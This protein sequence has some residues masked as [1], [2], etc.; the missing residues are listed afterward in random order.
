MKT[1]T[2]LSALMVISLTGYSQSFKT[3]QAVNS[4]DSIAMGAGYANDVYYSFED[5]VVATPPRTNWDIGFHT[6]VWTAS[7]ITNGAAGVNL[8][9]YPNSDTTGWN[10]VDTTG[11]GTWPVLYDSEND[12]EEGA[13]NRNQSGHP[14]YGWGKYNPITHDVVGDSIYILKALDGS[15]R[16]LWI[17]R[18]NSGANKY[19]VRHANLDGTDDQVDE[20]DINPYQNVNFIYFN[21]STGSFIEREP[22]T[23]SWDIQFTKYM[24]IQ[25]DGT[26]YPV[27]G[28][29]DNFK[30][31][32][33]EFYPVGPD[34]VDWMS[35]P[36]DSTK[37]PVGW[38]WKTF[39]M[40]TFT[41]TVADSTAFFVQ[42][43]KNNI[44]KLVFTKFEGSTTGKIV[45]EKSPMSSAGLVERNI[46]DEVTVFPN[47]VKDHFGKKINGNVRVVIYDIT[48]KQVYSSQQVISD[49]F[50]SVNMPESSLSNGLHLL[51]AETAEGIFSSKF[52]VYKN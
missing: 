29:L 19:F 39:D 24:A 37:S 3:G 36:L 45:F 20:L 48:G 21:I 17:L 51:K 7:I 42:T 38:E 52:M 8:Y 1:L 10:S 28:V 12:W 46:N 34:F 4:N 27:V 9:T 35:M 31:Y 22:D 6:T 44:Y 13:F 49:N 26:P 16:K 25:P 11:L 50:I 33:N 30:V 47:P 23:A 40:G 14:D 41:W 32:A 18:K 43:R 2:L 15:F 5:G